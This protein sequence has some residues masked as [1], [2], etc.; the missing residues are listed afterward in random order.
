MEK[1][2]TQHINFNNP[3]ESCD[4]CSTCDGGRCESCKPIYKVNGK[5]FLNIEEAKEHEEK[6]TKAYFYEGKWYEFEGLHGLTIVDDKLMGQVWITGKGNVLVELNPS[7]EDYD[8]L[9]KKVKKNCDR[10]NEC[11]CTDKNVVAYANCCGALKRCNNCECYKN[12]KNG[13]IERIY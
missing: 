9:Y 11:K 4:S 13:S 7:F 2:F 5:T 8:E 10:W 3:C 1:L 12:M 6:C